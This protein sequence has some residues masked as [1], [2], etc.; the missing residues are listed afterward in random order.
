MK[1]T[2]LTTGAAAVVAAGILMMSNAPDVPAGRVRVNYHD[3]TSG[4]AGWPAAVQPT[5]STDAE[6][7]DANMTTE[8]YRALRSSKQPDWDAWKA[9]Q[10]A[11]DRERK[12]KAKAAIGGGGH[13]A[14]AIASPDIRAH[15]NGLNA[16]D[17]DMLLRELVAQQLAERID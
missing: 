13:M 4:P 3:G 5:T 9:V 12:A 7:W 11:P 10:D 6:G 15:V 8:E 2:I 1:K 16:R 17:F 14:T